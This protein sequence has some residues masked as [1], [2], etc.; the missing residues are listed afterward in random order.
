VVNSEVE[1]IGVNQYIR[2]VASELIDL[3]AAAK[4]LG[5]TSERVRQLV[6]AGQL[7]GQRIGRSWAVPRSAISARGHQQLRRGRPLGSHR[8]WAE[9]ANAPIDLSHAVRYRNRAQTIACDLSAANIAALVSRFSARIG[10]VRAA[11]EHGELLSSDEPLDVYLSRSMY[12]A[13]STR[14]AIIDNSLSTTHL[15]VVEDVDWPV[16]TAS[17]AKDSTVMP[18]AVAALDL[19]DSS[20]PRHWVAAERLIARRA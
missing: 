16:A 13:A 11:V 9:I 14:M 1:Y 15:R 5:T 10:G 20:V 19:V 7:P 4:I 3:A 17:C 18:P 2:E 8:A 12:E 6:V